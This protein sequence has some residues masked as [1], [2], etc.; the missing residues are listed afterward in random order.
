MINGKSGSY[1]QIDGE[2]YYVKG[3]Y[4]TNITWKDQILFRTYNQRQPGGKYK[5]DVIRVLAWATEN[6]H[7]TEKQK[8]V[9]ISKFM[10]VL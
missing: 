1:F 6:K 3:V 4:R 5:S 10:K 7:I 8:E 9:L 2:A